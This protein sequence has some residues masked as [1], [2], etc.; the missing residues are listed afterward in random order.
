ME[1]TLYELKPVQNSNNKISFE[2][3]IIHPSDGAGLV[4][5]IQRT[6]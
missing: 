4:D 5:R 2:L 6:E 3:S 1:L